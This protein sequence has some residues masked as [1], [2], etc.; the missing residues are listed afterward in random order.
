MRYEYVHS[1]MEDLDLTI[2]S[3]QLLNLK[4]LDKIRMPLKYVKSVKSCNVKE[5][6]EFLINCGS[7]FIF[8]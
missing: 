4:A 1:A 5:P 7:L 8:L 3:R 2:V 6:L